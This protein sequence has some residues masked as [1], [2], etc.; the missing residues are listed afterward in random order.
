M[1]QHE[2]SIN[3]EEVKKQIMR[4]PHTEEL[5]D[6][7]WGSMSHMTSL[8]KASE[9][10][11]GLILSFYGI[12]LNFVYQSATAVLAANSNNIV[13]YILIGLWF[14]T[15]VASVFFSVRSFIPRIEGGY[16]RN[17]FFFGDV[18]TKFGTIKEFS[19][20]FYKIS[21]DE[22]E[23]FQQLGEQ[24][25]IISKIASWKFKNVNKSLKLL[26]LGLFFLLLVI[27]YYFIVTLF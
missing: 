25:F 9:L 27:I 4:S 3:E 8:I 20:S 1:E 5:V 14:I 7:Y 16:D 15:T 6:H 21:L 12:L 13:L 17:I 26:A 18:I 10:K 22:E 11:A 2:K 19:R 23:L 24:I